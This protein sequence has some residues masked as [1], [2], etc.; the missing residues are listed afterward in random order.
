MI[1][2][3]ALFMDWVHIDYNKLPVKSEKYTDSNRHKDFC[4]YS[5]NADGF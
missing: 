4:T 2:K 1:T 5:F 3:S